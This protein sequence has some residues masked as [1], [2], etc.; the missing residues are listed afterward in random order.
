[1]R[2]HTNHSSKR[3]VSALVLCIGVGFGLA[4][5]TTAASVSYGEYRAGPGYQAGHVHEHHVYGGT[6]QGIRSERC[7]VLRRDEIDAFGR[8]SSSEATVC[9]EF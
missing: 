8:A 7:Q 2:E 6:G 4:G 1:M 9:E 3:S 5:C